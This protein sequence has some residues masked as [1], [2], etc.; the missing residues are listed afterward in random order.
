[1]QEAGQIT[2]TAATQEQV[3]TGLQIIRASLAAVADLLV[4]S[5]P[6]PP[7]AMAATIRTS[8]GMF[9]DVGR[10]DLFGITM[11]VKPGQT[12]DLVTA[13]PS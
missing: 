9:G 4:F 5:D 8:D 1:M 13:S 12:V 7:A 3:W 10:P 11:G 6:E 2:A